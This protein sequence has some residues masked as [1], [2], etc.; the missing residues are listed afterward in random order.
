MERLLARLDRRLGKYAIENLPMLIVG[1]MGVVYL[2][3][4]S[5][6]EFLG[7]L[8]LVPSLVARGQVWRLF[9][10]LFIPD[11]GSMFWILFNLMW[12]WMVGSAL[13]AEWGAFKL[14]VYY[15]VGMLGTTVA[16][17]LT[18]EQGNFYLN[19]SMVFAF[20]TLFP[21]YEILLF[22][23]LPLK[24]KWLGWFAFAYVAFAFV[25][26]GDWATRAAIVAASSNYLLFFAP[27]LSLLVRG[28]RRQAQ[29]AARRASS[30]PPPAAAASRACAL[31]GAKEA[32]GAD[33]RVCSCEKCREAS[34]GKTREL[35][36]EHARNH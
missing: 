23:I 21:N 15:L 5:R 6:P 33:I 9:T 12:I 24:A 3:A 18:H 2:I 25:R 13:E 29:Q 14:N 35:C 31:C 16:A 34:G 27:T 36:L 30:A 26:S 32:D 10:Y 4:Y 1:G 28:G 22:L 19:L 11:T 7:A 20:A 8:T 17:L